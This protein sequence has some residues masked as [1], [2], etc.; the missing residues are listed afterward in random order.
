MAMDRNEFSWLLLHANRLPMLAMQQ[1]MG[2]IR[3]ELALAGPPP[4][5]GLNDAQ[6]EEQRRI[7]LNDLADR[8]EADPELAALTVFNFAAPPLSED[9]ID[10]LQQQSR[11]EDAAAKAAMANLDELPAGP[12]DLDAFLARAYARPLPASRVDAAFARVDLAALTTAIAQ[13]PDDLPPLTA[14]LNGAGLSR[15]L[16][17]FRVEDSPCEALVLA[18]TRLDEGA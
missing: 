8:I 1:M 12:L 18:V 9:E 6:R 17:A 13:L 16:A 14:A 11:E 2:E 7:A 10:R 4:D 3:D 15:W 5:D